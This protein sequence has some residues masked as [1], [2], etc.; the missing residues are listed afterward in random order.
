MKKIILIILLFSAFITSFSQRINYHSRVYDGISFVPISGANIFNA[1][2]NQ[3]VFSDENGN[4]NIL[5]SVK[6]TLIISKSIYRQL[7][8]VITEDLLKRQNEDFFLYYKAILLKEVNVIALNPNYEG[9]KRDISKIKLPDIYNKIAGTEMSEWDQLNAEF[10]N[11]GPNVFRNTPLASPITFLYEK[12]SKKAKMKQ[13]YNEMVKYEAEIDKVPAKYNRELVSEITGLKGDELMK[14][15]VF[16]RFSYYD[17][18]RWT[19]EEVIGAVKY[20]FSEYEYYKAVQ[21]E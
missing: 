18:I 19:P 12:F 4:F 21:D 7:L 2:T 5:V 16:C 8:V 13:L 10:G 6:D 17:L 1:S 20:R 11:K 14:F 15:M 3:Y 9:F